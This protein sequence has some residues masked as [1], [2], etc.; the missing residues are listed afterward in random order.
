MT[1]TARD[2]AL[3]VVAQVR[4][5]EAYSNLV[6]PTALRAAGLSSRNA[7]H[8]TD[9]V[10]GAL[11]WQKL[12]DAVIARCITGDPA[13]VDDDVR[14]LLRLGTYELIIRS[15]PPHVINEW[16]NCANRRFRR[17]AGFVNA[18]LRAVSRRTPDD[19]CDEVARGLGD[20]ERRAVLGSHPEWIVRVFTD[21][22]GEDEIDELLA[23][24]NTPPVPTLVALPRLAT[25]P[26]GAD[27][28]AYSP[29]G[30]RSPGGVLTD[31]NGFS[32]GF[33]RAQDEGSQL[34]ALALVAVDDVHEGERWLDL[35]AGPGGKT[36][37]LAAL[38]IPLGVRLDAN[39]VQDHRAKL[40]RTSLSPFDD[41]VPVTVEDGRDVCRAHRGEYDRILVDAPCTG[42]G[43]LRRR[44][45]ARWRKSPVDLVDLVPLQK[46]LLG[47]ALGALNVGG[48]VAYVTCSPHPAE[49]DE[50]VVAVLANHPEAEAVD[51]PAVLRR[52]APGIEGIVRGTAVQLWPHRHNTDAMFIQLIR[53]TR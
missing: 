17:A 31:I 48:V 1:T 23:A 26:V 12:I 11:R 43:A 35:C 32:E 7:G 50:V 51:T 20:I 24:D 46:E 34:A 2:V 33:V 39:E 14:D 19:W 47:A 25:I 6:L 29:H 13:R 16:V 45:E 37:L 5:D 3:D 8:A 9:L 40:V 36:A 28:T 21:S 49:T 18:T 44:P 38:G 52:I 42:L 22:V 27:A 30:F 53:R 10:Y 41:A 4:T 15:E